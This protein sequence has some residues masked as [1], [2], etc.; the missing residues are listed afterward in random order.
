MAKWSLDKR[1]AEVRGVLQELKQAEPR[2]AIL[3]GA[4]MLE[5]TLEIAIHGELESRSPPLQPK[6]L[7]D[8]QQGLFATFDRKIEGAYVLNLVGKRARNDIDLV[9]R[10]RNHCAHTLKR[11]SFEAA[12]ISDLCRQFRLTGSYFAK[13]MEGSKSAHLA[14]VDSFGEHG[15]SL[16]EQFVFVVGLI[17]STLLMRFA[18]QGAKFVGESAETMARLF[19]AGLDIDV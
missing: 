15:D 19:K 4:S 14:V 13:V 8:E 7:F 16:R 18:A 12:P 2:S 10:A 3:L 1:L 9:R 6:P 5:C 11:V 17:S